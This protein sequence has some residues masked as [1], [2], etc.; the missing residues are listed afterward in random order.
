MLMWAGGLHQA[1][2]RVVTDGKWGRDL[3]RNSRN[4]HL[5]FASESSENTL[6]NTESTLVDI[7]LV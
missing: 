3:F 2:C 5:V 4:A 6:H 1:E 7:C